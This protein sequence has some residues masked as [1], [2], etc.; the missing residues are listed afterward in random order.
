MPFDEVRKI[1]DEF[2]G[3]ADK[4]KGYMQTGGNE[5]LADVGW[6]AREAGG[7]IRQGIATDRPEL[8]GPNAD[9]TFFKR[10]NDVLDP[11]AGR[12]KATSYVPTGITGGMAATGAII[13]E[14]LSNVPGL[15]AVGALVGSQL[16]P[17]L[18]AVMASPEWQLTSATKKMA[19]AD[20]IEKGQT[21]VAQGILLKIASGARGAPRT[22]TADGLGGSPG[23]N[24]PTAPPP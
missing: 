24:S 16:L 11:T 17:K 14:G 1:R 19:L 18:K 6:A 12:P 13:G 3:A 22:L 2:Y 21:S 8:Q 20:A 23:G 9:Y 5:H 4:A 15:K 7:A 10:L